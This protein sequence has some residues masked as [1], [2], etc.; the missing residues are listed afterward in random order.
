MTQSKGK[1]FLAGILGAVAGAI[2]G[3]LF[4]P[5]SGEETREDIAKLAADISKKVKTE[6]KETQ[7]RVQEVFGEASETAMV[8]YNE[9]KEAVTQKVA[10]VKTAGEDIDKEKYGKIVEGVVEEFKGD[11]EAT[12][13]GAT[14]LIAQLK[15]DW[16]KI[17][18]ALG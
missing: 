11:L 14:K 13:S 12:K 18:K 8:K 4:A 15:K 3:L 7:K 2:G 9:I 1:F 17:K 6:A 5:Q 10:S 16:E